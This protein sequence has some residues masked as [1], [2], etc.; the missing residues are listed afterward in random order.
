MKWLVRGFVI[1]FLAGI[2]LAS[3]AAAQ[4]K[5]P[6]QI[7]RDIDAAVKKATA[8]VQQQVASVTTKPDP[9]TALPCDFK[10]LTKLTADNLVPTM[11]ACAQDV[12]NQL[13]SD[14]SRALASAQA[15]GCN[16][17][18]T[19]CSGDGDAI[20]CL[21]P[22]LAIFKAG[23]IIPAVPATATTPAV[24]EQDPGPILLYQKYREFTLAGALTSCQA[25]FNGPINA[26]AAAGIAGVAT[27]V[28]GA[29]LL[30]PK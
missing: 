2:G 16:G 7:Q 19:G 28:S 8:G 27:A 11:K 22:A 30:V 10:M 12:N 13:V 9:S 17:S 6:G 29:A 3:P 24:P 20:N 5:T 15:Y 4:L 14:T 1:A 26:T 18:T 21:Q 23:A 25:W